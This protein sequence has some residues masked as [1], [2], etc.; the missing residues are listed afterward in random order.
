MCVCVCVSVGAC[1]CMRLCASLC[2][3]ECMSTKVCVCVCARMCVCVYKVI[4]L[5]ECTCTRA[6]TSRCACLCVRVRVRAYSGRASATQGQAVRGSR[7]V[8]RS[9]ERERRTCLIRDCSGPADESP[10]LGPRHKASL[11][12]SQRA[13]PPSPTPTHKQNRFFIVLHCRQQRGCTVLI[14]NKVPNV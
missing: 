7:G 13:H 12:L 1:M 11:L 4:V 14:T 3:S 5:A 2:A 9:G 8:W 10:E 6:C